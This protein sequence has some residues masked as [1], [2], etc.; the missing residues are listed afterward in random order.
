MNYVYFII[1]I[2]YIYIYYY[3]TNE[4]FKG[5][6]HSRRKREA[7]RRRREAQKR[8]E[9]AR[10]LRD[11]K[12]LSRNIV[13][14]MGQTNNQIDSAYVSL[15]SGIDENQEI[16]ENKHQQISEL[17]N[18]KTQNISNRL[19]NEITGMSKGANRREKSN[20]R[21]LDSLNKSFLKKIRGMSKGADK[22]NKSN[23][24]I[25]KVMQQN[26]NQKLN[27]IQNNLV[28]K[29]KKIK[30]DMIQGDNE[31][32]DT[33]NSNT[34]ASDYQYERILGMSKGINRREVK[35]DKINR[36]NQRKFNEIDE[37]IGFNNQEINIQRNK[38]KQLQKESILKEKQIKELDNALSNSEKLL[39][40]INKKHSGF[41]RSIFHF[42]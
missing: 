21:R 11:V 24:R 29:T 15:K 38:I 20:Q 23:Q 32:Q 25:F 8:L 22:R 26:F 31:L 28:N 17:I 14:N 7:E 13:N 41:F 1:I 3:T 9:R 5:Y 6:D 37:K 27:D 36:L 42:L 19:D 2:I 39:N 40:K 30:I 33:I 4:Y 16:I 10:N 34:N 12:N 35:N 18:N